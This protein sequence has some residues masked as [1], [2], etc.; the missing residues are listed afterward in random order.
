VAV[1]VPETDLLD[2]PRITAFGLLVEAGTAVV[3]VLDE[4]LRR[5]VGMPL[6]TYETLLRLGRSPGRRLQQVELSR[7]LSLTT[8]GVTRLVD[9]LEAA[10]LVRR[11]FRPDDRRASYAELTEAGLEAVERATRVHLDGVQRHLVDP[12]GADGLA[13]LLAPLRRLRD[14]HRGDPAAD[15]AG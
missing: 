14:S 15:R 13:A 2:D 3:R 1:P 11:T 6:G 10:G 4:E 7:Q 9:R 12:L 8:G 5:D